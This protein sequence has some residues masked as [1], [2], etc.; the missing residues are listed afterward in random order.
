M[1]RPDTTRR[2]GPAAGG[3]APERQTWHG[4]AIM[5]AMALTDERHRTDRGVLDE[6]TSGPVA[7]RGP[8]GATVRNRTARDRPWMT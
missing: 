4:R 7:E 5:N 2:C 6:V 8:V 3:Y 1:T